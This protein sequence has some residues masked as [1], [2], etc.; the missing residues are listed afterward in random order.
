MEAEPS[1]PHRLGL[2][3]PHHRQ[4]TQVKRKGH[5]GNAGHAR[6]GAEDAT[7]ATEIRNRT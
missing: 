6:K 1:C 3:G 4:V 5:I 7:W 2:D